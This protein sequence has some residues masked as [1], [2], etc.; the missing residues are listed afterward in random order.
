[1]LAALSLPTPPF[2]VIGTAT[3]GEFGFPCR[4]SYDSRWVVV[5][6]MDELARVGR[7]GEVVER[8]IENVLTIAKEPV[9]VGVR[10]AMPT[11]ERVRTAIDLSLDYKVELVSTRG[12]NVWITDL[13][14]MERWPTTTN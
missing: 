2:Y 4:V 1:M 13:V 12:G 11:A 5:R 7:H 6:D 14:V 10:S 3:H 8:L 9:L